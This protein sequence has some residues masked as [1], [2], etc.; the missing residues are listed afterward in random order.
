MGTPKPAPPG[1]SVLLENRKVCAVPNPLQT[2]PLGT[3]MVRGGGGPWRSR[4]GGRGARGSGARSSAWACL[5]VQGWASP[6]HA[7]QQTRALG[8]GIWLPDGVRT[9]ICRQLPRPL[10]C[11]EDHRSGARANLKA[12]LALAPPAAWLVLRLLSRALLL[13]EI[14]SWLSAIV[15]SHPHRRPWK[16]GARPARSQD[17]GTGPPRIVQTS[18]AAR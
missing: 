4:R 18:S 15:Q 16:P 3:T 1:C 2:P 7:S 13:A 9:G 8:S 5:S 11:G 6:S 12:T 14:P 17:F 10:H